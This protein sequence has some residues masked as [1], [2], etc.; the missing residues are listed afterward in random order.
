MSTIHRNPDGTIGQPGF[1]GHYTCEGRVRR[2]FRRVQCHKPATIAVNFPLEPEG[3]AITFRYC[4]A[5]APE[6]IDDAG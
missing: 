3:I 5:C 4:A 2:W 6:D 1:A